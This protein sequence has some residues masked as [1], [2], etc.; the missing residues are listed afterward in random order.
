[1]KYIRN[2]HTNTMEILTDTNMNFIRL[3]WFNSHKLQSQKFSAGI[4]NDFIN[5]FNGIIDAEKVFFSFMDMIGE[6]REIDNSNIRKC[7][8][9]TRS[10]MMILAG[11]ELYKENRDMPFTYNHMY[12][13]I[14]KFTKNNEISLWSGNMSKDTSSFRD[15][16]R[17]AMLEHCPNSSQYWFRCNSMIQNRDPPLFINRTIGAENM[18]RNWVKGNMGK[19]YAKG[20]SWEFN[21]AC[22]D[23][24]KL[25]CIESLNVPTVHRIKLHSDMRNDGQIYRS[26]G[27]A[28]KK[29]HDQCSLVEINF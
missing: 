3:I 19:N 21:I 18:K 13:K 14:L 9:Y 7:N 15:Q 17:T 16:I 5:Y 10:L 28:I 23:E 11:H 6:I 4:V 1:M 8:K 12:E 25:S 24:H 22:L 20:C 29:W 26:D 2:K 27:G